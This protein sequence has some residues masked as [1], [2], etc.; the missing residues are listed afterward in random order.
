MILLFWGLSG[1]FAYQ[2][3]QSIN[4]PIK[5]EKVKKE[6]FA[7]AIKKLKD[8]RDAQEAYRSVT[9]GFANDFESLVK[10]VDT[11]E[12]VLTQQRDSSY[13]EFSQVYKIDQLKEVVIIDTLGYRSVKDS[14]FGTSDRYRTMMDVPFAQN[15][16]KFELKSDILDKN[17]YRAA[18]FEAKVKKDI[19]LWDQPKDLLAQENEQVSVDEVNGTE[20]IL[21]SL[22][23][24]STNGNW[25]PLYDTKKDR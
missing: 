6:R 23:D 11:A 17:G 16:E 1:L 8:I 5:F 20:I 12:F 2:I 24:V 25:P 4:L 19:I 14:L 13:M 15:N 3:Y 9:G 21:G 22:T 18:V 10:F 7:E